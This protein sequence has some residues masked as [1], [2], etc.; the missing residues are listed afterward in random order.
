MYL[1]PMLWGFASTRARVVLAVLWLLAVSGVLRGQ[2]YVLAF[3]NVHAADKRAQTV[4]VVVVPTVATEPAGW[5]VTAIEEDI[6]QA[7][8]DVAHVDA[9]RRVGE[10]RSLRMRKMELSAQLAV[11]D[12]EA[13][14]TKRLA[15]EQDWRRDQVS[16]AQ[17]L[18]ESR[19]AE[20]GTALVAPWLGTTEARLD[21]LMNF[22]LVVVLELQSAIMSCELRF[23]ICQLV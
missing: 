16:R 13:N 9:R 12:A 4:A 15:A 3:A 8:I 1:A 2:V 22:V 5:S 19:R 10:C 21:L 18:R 14:A 6:A 23:A 11:L 17:A 20:R 7:S